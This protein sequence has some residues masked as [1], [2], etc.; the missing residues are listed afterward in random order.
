[1]IDV[2]AQFFLGN[3]FV[4][5]KTGIWTPPKILKI[6]QRRHNVEDGGE[7]D[8]GNLVGE[9]KLKGS[10]M[11]SGLEDSRPIREHKI[12]I[13]HSSTC[14]EVGQPNQELPFGPY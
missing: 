10:K 8:N 9:K 3:G 2:M 11:Q 7:V 14:F 12:A 6:S 4:H 5:G 13:G 1:M